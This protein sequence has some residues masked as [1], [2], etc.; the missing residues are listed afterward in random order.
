MK[1][2]PSHHPLP[3][4]Q[5]AH[6][7]DTDLVSF[8]DVDFVQVRVAPSAY[9]IHLFGKLRIPPMPDSGPAYVHFRLFIPGKDDPA[10]LHCIHT[11]EKELAD[12]GFAYRAI[13]TKNDPLEWFDN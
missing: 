9:G 5:Q 8:T 7:S 13:F 6:L 10:T 3:Q 1:A 2:S 11:E 4:T 12:G